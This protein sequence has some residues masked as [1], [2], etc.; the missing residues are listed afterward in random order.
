MIY[1]C[2]LHVKITFNLNFLNLANILRIN[3]IM[4][5]QWLTFSLHQ[6]VYA[7]NIMQLKEVIPYRAITKIPACSSCIIGVINLRGTIVNVFDIAKYLNLASCAV[8]LDSKILITE[9]NNNILGLLVNNVIEVITVN[10]AHI[11]KSYQEQNQIIYGLYH[12]NKQMIIMLDIKD[13]F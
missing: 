4:S 8:N 6:E 2:N 12:N 3:K 10:N 11:R 13:I 9:Q 5:N 7:L 1:I